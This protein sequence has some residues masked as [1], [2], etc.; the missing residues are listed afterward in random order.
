M[1]GTEKKLDCCVVRDL[2]PSYIEELT[3]EE[4]TALIRAHLEG[5]PGCREVEQAMRA[6]VPVERAPKRALRFLRRVKR[7][8]L[9][10][11][12]LSVLAALWCM[13]WLYDQAF[14]Y[15]NTETGRLAAVED[16]IPSPDTSLGLTGVEEGTPLEVVGWQTREDHLLSS[17]WQTMKSRST[18]SSIWSGAST[19]NTRPWKRICLPP[20]IPPG[21]T[22][23]I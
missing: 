7:T 17:I 13:W 1:G 20:P 23:A 10:A 21:S 11:A 6:A 4:T 9:L 3:E 2:L 22:G 5:C 15:A 8:R 16:Y 19:G 14:H 12:V 18:A